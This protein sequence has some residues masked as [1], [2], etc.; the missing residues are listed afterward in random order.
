MPGFILSTALALALPQLAKSQ[1]ATTYY[2]D[3][4]GNPT[5]GLYGGT[6]NW[7]TTVG[8]NVWDDNVLSPNVPWVNSPGSP[9]SAIFAGTGGTVTLQQPIVVNQIQ[10]AVAGY[11][12]SNGGN[13]SNTLNFVSA[14]STLP[15]IQLATGTLSMDIAFVG[16]NGFVKSGAGTLVLANPEQTYTGITRI[17]GGVLEVNN[18]GNVGQNSSIGRGYINTTPPGSSSFLTLDGGTLRYVGVGDATNH[19]L[20][21]GTN[22]GTI[23]SSGTSG[24]L[25][26]SRTSVIGITGTGPRTLTFTGTNKGLNGFASK[27]TDDPVSAA[28]TSVVKSGTGTWTL[29]GNNDYTGSTTI[30]GGILSVSLI[31]SGGSAGQLGKSGPQATN[32]VINGGT[33]RYTGGANVVDRLFT[34]GSN[35]ATIDGSGSGALTFTG[36]GVLGASGSGDRTLTLTG[37]TAGNTFRPSIG[38]AVSLYGLNNANQLLAFS[39]GAPDILQTINVSGL[40]AGDSLQA[41]DFRPTTGELYG[42]G[43]NRIYKINPTTGAVTATLAN[44]PNFTLGGGSYG[45]DINPINSEIRIVN[46]TT[47]QNF[48]VNPD[49]GALIAN[50]TA[51]TYSGGEL[52][53]AGIAYGPVTSGGT[54][55]YAID[56]GFD[57]LLKFDSET[58]GVLSNVGAL[59][60]NVTGASPIGLGFDIMSSGAA[61]A[62]M[63]DGSGY[64]LY[65]INLTTGS[66]NRLGLI[67]D[68]TDIIRDVTGNVT[69][70]VS[71]LKTGSGTWTL[72]RAGMTTGHT[73]TGSTTINQGSLILNFNQ[74]TTPDTNL[75]NSRSALVMGGGT[76]GITGKAPVANFQGFASLT[77]LPGAS[78]ITAAPGTSAT[79]NGSIALEVGAITRSNNATIDFPAAATTTTSTPNGANGIIGPW[80]TIRSTTGSDWATATGGPGSYT[81]AAYTGYTDVSLGGSIA[82]SATSN[83]RVNG[84]TTGNITL[85]ATTTNAYTLLQNLGTAATISIPGGSTLRL[86]P[87]GGILVGASKQALTIGT[88][89]GTGTLTAG[90]TVA[91]NPGE[92]LLLNYSGNNLTINSLITNNGSGAVTVVNSGTGVSILNAANTYTGGTVLNSGTLRIGNDRALSTGDVTVNGGT[93]LPI[94]ASDGS[95]DREITNNFVL[96]SDIQFTDATGTGGLLLKGNINLTGGTRAMSITNANGYVTLTGS[97]TN[98][99]LNKI[100]G[101]GIALVGASLALNDVTLTAGSI[102][103]WSANALGSTPV[104]AQGGTLSAAASFNAPVMNPI[105]LTG[106]MVLGRAA[107]SDGIDLGGIIDLSNNQIISPTASRTISA[108][109]GQQRISGTI[110]NGGLSKSGT[111]D[112]FITGSS[113]T[114]SLG[115]LVMQGSLRV[116][117]T[118]RLGNNVFG[119]NVRVLPDLIAASSVVANTFAILRLESMSNL[120]SNQQLI[121]NNFYDSTTPLLGWNSVFLANYDAINFV[122]FNAG[123]G[124]NNI[125]I[126]SDFG[127]APVGIAL[128]GIEMN[129]DV[130]SKITAATPNAWAWLGATTLNGSY[131]AST[132]DPGP[133]V[134]VEGVE[135]S[136]PTYR[137]GA[138]G[139]TLT[140]TG[141][142][143]LTGLTDVTI[144]SY[145]TQGRG[146]VG[147]VYV[148]N[149]QDFSGT[150]TIGSGGTY[151]A[152]QNGA[153]GSGSAPI[154]LMGGTL[155]LRS[156]GFHNSVDN[157]Y[158]NRNFNIYSSGLTNA[159]NPSI[160]VDP[161][162]GGQNGIVRIGGLDFTN[163]AVSPTLSFNISNNFDLH[164]AGPTTLLTA[165]ALAPTAVLTTSLSVNSGF[166]TFEQPITQTASSTAGANLTKNGG[167]TLIFTVPNSYTGITTVGAG[168]L[169]LT[170][171]N[172]VSGPMQINNGGTLSLRSN[173][174]S[175]VDLGF[176]TLSLNTGTGTVYVGP[177]S[178]TGVA[179]YSGTTFRV[180]VLNTLSLTATPVTSSGFTLNGELNS[181]LQV[182]GATTLGANFT[183]TVNSARLELKGNI[184]ESTAVANTTG[185]YSLT[186]A[187]IGMLTLSGAYVPIASTNGNTIVNQGTLVLNH[188][189]GGT[190]DALG[191]G[192]LNLSGTSSSGLLI[193]G[194]R[195]LSKNLT[196]DATGGNQVLGGLDAGDKIFGGNVALS[197]TSGNIGVF[198]TA[199][200]GSTVSFNGTIS[201]GAGGAVTIGSLTGGVLTSAT[202]TAALGRGTIIFDPSAG[203]GNSFTVPL[204]VNNG[205]LIG[206]A[207]ATSGSPFGN[208]AN[209]ITI[210]QGKLQLDGRAT[211]TST[212][213]TGALTIGGGATLAVNASGGASTQFAVGN[214]TRATGGS[215]VYTPVVGSGLERFTVNGT[216]TSVNG[217]LAPWLVKTVSGADLSADFTTLDIANKDVINATYTGSDID[218]SLGNTAIIAD[219]DGGT[220]TASRAA[221]ALKLG[222]N[223]SLGTNT[224]AIGDTSAT[225]G[226][227]GLILNSGASILGGT[228]NF[229]YGE[230]L[231]YVAGGGTSTISS[232]I[233][234]TNSTATTGIANTNLTKFGDG[235][236]ILTNANNTYRGNTVVAR[237]TLKMGAT[238][239]LGRSTVSGA[240]V[241]S[242]LTVNANGVLDL[243]GFDTEVGSLAGNFGA[244]VDLKNNRLTVGRSSTVTTT[245]SGK[246]SGGASSV[247]Q[248]IGTGTL[249]LDNTRGDANGSDFSGSVLVDQGTLQ[250][251]VADQSNG[252]PF[253]VGNTLRS[254]T[255]FTLRGGTLSLRTSGDNSAANQTLTAGYNIIVTG[256]TSILNT[257]RVG[258]AES[259]KV[260][261]LGSLTLGR[262]EFQTTGGNAIRAKFTGQTTLTD[263]ARINNNSIELTL[264]GIVTDNGAGY[265]LNKV[266]GSNLYLNNASNGYS[267]G[268]VLTGGQLF[269]GSFGADQIKFPGA[270]VTPSETAKAGTGPILLNTNSVIN[271]NDTSNLYLGQ[272]VRVISASSTNSSA[273]AVVLRT[274]RSLAEYFI[275]ASGRVALE[276][277]VNGG[278]V[279]T[280][281]NLSQLGDGNWGLSAVSQSIYTP[282]TLGAGYGNVYRFYGSSGGAFTIQEANVLTGTSTV[283]LGKTLVDLGSNPGNSNASIQFVTDQNYTGNTLIHRAANAGGASNALLDF[284]GTLASPQLEVYG[285]LFATGAGTFTNASGTQVN[286]VLM[287]PGG[288]LR[289]DYNNNITGFLVPVGASSAGGFTNKWQDNLGMTLDGS[290]LRL[291]SASGAQSTEVVGSISYKGGAEIFPESAGTG[292]L[293]VLIINGTVN[294]V[295]LGTLAIRGTANQLGTVGAPGSVNAQR[296][297]F[298]NAANAP[299]RGVVNGGAANGTTV[300]MVSAQFFDIG[301]N[302]FLDY[303]PAGT[304]LGFR[305]VAFTSSVNNGAFNLGAAGN[306]T[307]ILDHNTTATST[308]TDA[309]IWALR[310]SV[311]VSGTGAIT[312]RS[313]G[314]ATL[315]NT[316]TIANPLKFMNNTAVEADIWALS[317]G[318]TTTLS[319]AITANNFVKNGPGT[320]VVSGTNTGTLTGNIQINGG[321]L[322]FNSPAASNGLPIRIHAGNFNNT[323]QQMSQLNLL[324]APAT[325]QGT[326]TYGGAITISEFVPFATITT[327]TSNTTFTSF[328]LV[329]PSLTIEGGGSDGTVLSF[330]NASGVTFRV[331]GNTVLT[332]TGTNLP[333][334][335]N[336]LGANTTV[337]S[338][339]AANY[340]LVELAGPVSG[341]AQIVKSGAGSSPL[342]LSSPSGNTFTGGVVIN[343]GTFQLRNTGGITLGTQMVGTGAIEINRGTLQLVSDV[344]NNM[345][346]AV[347]NNLTTRGHAVIT[348]DR[349]VTTTGTPAVALGNN[350]SVF[351]TQNSGIV[352]FNTASAGSLTWNGRTVINDSPTINNTINVQLGNGTAAESITGVGHIYKSGGGT[353]IFASTVANSLSGGIDI[354]QGQVRVNFLGDTFGT[355]LIRV[356]PDGVI[357]V[358]GTGNLPVGASQIVN[359]HSNSTAMAGLGIR[360]DVAQSTLTSFLTS[361]A[362]TSGS[363][364][365]GLLALD[366]PAGTFANNIDLTTLYNGY[367]FLGSTGTTSFTGTIGV[368]KDNTYRLVGGGGTLT[369]NNALMAG[370]SNKVLI[371]NPNSLFGNGSVVIGST[372]ATNTNSYGGGTTISRVRDSNANF[373]VAQLFVRQGNLSTPLGTGAVEVYGNLNFDSSAGAATAGATSLNTNAYNF[374]PGGRLIINNSTAYTGGAAGGR[375]GDSAPI[376]LRGSSLELTGFNGSNTF[377]T[378]S[379]GAVSYSLGSELRVIRQGSSPAVLTLASLNRTGTGSTLAITHTAPNPTVVFGVVGGEQIFVTAG[380]PVTNGIVAPNIIS[381]TDN[382]FLRYD[383]TNGLQVITAAG[384]ANYVNSTGATITPSALTRTD[385]S[386]MLNNGTEIFDANIAGTSTLAGN[387]DVYAL[388][389]QADISASSN[390]SFRQITIRSGGLTVYGGTARTINTDVVFGTT[391]SPAEA[392]IHA[393]SAQL[394]INGRITAS[395]ITKF[396]LNALAINQDQTGYTG[397]WN[398]NQGQLIIQ[399]PGGLGNGQVFLNG[400]ANTAT[401]GQTVTELRLNFNPGTP[402]ELTFSSGKITALDMNMIRAQSANDRIVRIGDIDLKTT[403]TVAA[404]TSNPGVIWL[405][406][407]GSRSLMR[408]GIIKMFDE[409]VLNVDATSF[410]PGS[411]AGVQPDAINNQGQYNLTKTGDGVLILGNNATTF[412]GGKTITVNE[413]AVKVL[414]NAS[415]GVAGNTA[416]IDN[417]GALEIA[418]TN[419]SPSATLVQRAGSI[420]RWAVNGARTGTVNLPSGVHLQIAANQTWSG[421]INLN[422][423]SLMGY[424]PVDIDSV[425]VYYNLGSG[426]AVNLQ[427][428]SYLGQPYP[429]GT[430][431]VN[432]SA[433]HIYYDMGKQNQ[434]N[435]PMDSRINGAVLEIKGNI[436]GGGSQTLTKVGQD[437]VV[438]SGNNTG[439]NTVIREGM[440]QIGSA[441]ALPSDKTVTMG[442]T[443]TLDLNGFNLSVSVVQGDAPQSV[444]T[445]SSTDVK[446]LTISPTTPASYSGALTGTIGLTK[447]GSATFTLNGTSTHNGPTVVASGTLALGASGSIG[448]SS[449]IDVK[450][451]ATFDVSAV[452]GGFQLKS[453]QTLAGGNGT[454]AGSVAG[455]VTAKSGSTISPGSDLRQTGTLSFSNGLTFEA[456]SHLQL[457]IGT[458][459]AGTGY[460][461]IQ[462]ASGTLTLGGDLAGSN[463]IGDYN[464][465]DIFYIILHGGS[466]LNIGTF[467]GIPQMSYLTI[468]SQVFQINYFADSGLGVAGFNSTAGND[469]ALRAIPEPS[470]LAS[471]ALGLGTLLGLRRGRRR[472]G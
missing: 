49:T 76:L 44:T 289:F 210:N 362:I 291:T 319:G 86:G 114:Y 247:L 207:Q 205:T 143:V 158:V 250:T 358:Q 269:F 36:L 393:S 280:A 301:A 441:T 272:T 356:S 146:L 103:L 403:S 17:S 404:G 414:N 327:N 167:G 63:T 164:V 6:G 220:L 64:R 87:V 316:L 389:T 198:L 126:P 178:S 329:V 124:L 433:N 380:V 323:G 131:T 377:N 302:Q 416:I 94:L 201:G 375:W 174:S 111:G 274:D 419:F 384:T 306:G 246:L 84:G 395:D 223:L 328:N 293:P 370:A 109:A 77:L 88:A 141:P 471:I 277:G 290:T 465:N 221:Y 374:H 144:G 429:A 298:A 226:L 225:T 67:G 256:G 336:I 317:S 440:I 82:D 254:G 31:N 200:Q 37:S 139:G 257:D 81:I 184:V 461:Q 51:L 22:G 321:I 333:I 417:G 378:E 240:V 224:L 394:T 23:D 379:V 297:I 96:N 287:R 216:A 438:L 386:V 29:T 195:T 443:G 363:N 331:S 161:L 163:V 150:L 368:G 422:G 400:W 273:S 388:R 349:M 288:E 430:N 320:V 303:D 57:R 285:R 179:T 79:G 151:I 437:L 261:E 300:P 40:V 101:G 116:S 112:L 348:V 367:W 311:N 108:G 211:A 251:T 249:V 160:N 364:V 55:L 259:A 457:E 425:A 468:A 20:T 324:G 169:V 68:G 43:N 427:A 360:A 48:R 3:P 30:N 47:N 237:G 448:N 399:T 397:S 275:R 15:G 343:D 153:L 91:N 434:L 176:S 215:L 354:T 128:D 315:T 170:T 292:G 245:Y 268:T 424:L 208:G 295:N 410:G 402:D 2:W 192:N 334:G 70:A 470:S 187:G 80:A 454:V 186:K 415:F 418:T 180:P 387:L 28:K 147:T 466:G 27:I 428:N 217:I 355:G 41:I 185:G 284:R 398:V 206:K 337:G 353:L 177:I 239:A 35:G 252:T 342:V 407:D 56:Y 283:E 97:V 341:S 233:T 19:L 54:T 352:T 194:T 172:A 60:E 445:N 196:L 426:I 188:D 279:G 74:T 444:I 276:Y 125:Y 155:A 104:Y 267:G 78:V 95:T 33:L 350:S 262:N 123:T 115:T 271:L 229:G 39:P 243:N 5:N 347:G 405:R 42:L 175:P 21:L 145:D 119:N 72:D 148:P 435:N 270:N 90:G 138:G 162:F 102:D 406:V 450:S 325:Q 50:D 401:N 71:L 228:L 121:L 106:N 140:V 213:T 183:F 376:D 446:M 265:T 46:D 117:P 344:G 14:G 118:G 431:V 89:A 219:A 8:N 137:L 282:K 390:D 45:F 248:K 62:S 156:S 235:T 83:V 326:V 4:D 345:A 455:A 59:S 92:L 452:S 413:G 436:S 107:I 335:F 305:Q 142:N 134:V 199:E 133:A 110:T 100:G 242:G 357:G 222:G 197:T 7:N 314:L 32:L 463:V 190:V 157:Q 304:Q 373:T 136:N 458:A 258:T 230:G 308:N 189:T 260:I 309:D 464:E 281:L 383:P 173:S 296:V 439:F 11:T 58:G 193:S 154:L 472:Q 313:G 322:Q 129:R 385:A 359:F 165:T 294:R 99:S 209:A 255:T 442:S 263:N 191:S 421:T 52:N 462:L 381:R 53:V 227:G 168:T 469:V 166:V 310:T 346:T 340:G 449:K 369:I 113:S 69:G 361:A 231:V 171:P 181:S 392:L 312:I 18:L 212:T 9:L 299:A 93:T 453:G 130:M 412:T 396:G 409:Y 105:Y 238:N 1:S 338:G 391:A 218:A 132:M 234:G 241:A 372:A 447:A 236:L 120:G 371:G 85:G 332:N 286:T 451:S 408:T 61:Y 459:T 214:L 460:D 202:G 307:A 351:A 98:G 318:V 204:V 26:F 149:P 122:G 330:N 159:T 10:I 278:V 366:V 244:T 182:M 16:T 12:F 467:A 266:G 365:G 420:E 203:T 127:F 65:S 411:T 25:G 34:I 152:G 423:G 75:I 456:G 135:V 38:D 66:T 13:A 264:D 24:S 73:Y 382:Q 432:G 232:A 339:F 253:A